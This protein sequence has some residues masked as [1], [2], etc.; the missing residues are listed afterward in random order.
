M[1]EITIEMF[2]I[3]KCNIFSPKE[4]SSFYA[5]TKITFIAYCFR[6]VYNRADQFVLII[7]KAR[8]KCFFK[9]QTNY[10]III[11]LNIYF[12][13]GARNIFLTKTNSSSYLSFYNFVFL[14]WC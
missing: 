4:F 7:L 8:T 14:K 13:V 11:I 9:V 6:I 3:Y 5:Q 1:C 12:A 10:G 2:E